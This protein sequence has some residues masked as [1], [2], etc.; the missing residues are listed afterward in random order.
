MQEEDDEVY[1]QPSPYHKHLCH[2]E[3]VAFILH[4]PDIKTQHWHCEE[5]SPQCQVC[6]IL[7]FIMFLHPFHITQVFC[8]YCQRS[9]FTFHISPFTFSP[10]PS[11][12]AA[13]ARRVVAERYAA[14][15]TYGAANVQ[16]AVAEFCSTA[17]A[18]TRR[19]G[20]G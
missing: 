7:I 19:E 3:G 18:N 13:I 4:H 12:T 17:D 2:I 1:R 5:H 14:A 8:N 6:Q 10:L 15:A 9:P 16:R 11:L 20:R